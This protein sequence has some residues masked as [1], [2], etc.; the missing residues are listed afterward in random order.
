M[1]AVSVCKKIAADFLP[2]ISIITLCAALCLI[3][4]V[5][6]EAI[7]LDFGERVTVGLVTPVENNTGYR[8]WGSKYYPATYFHRRWRST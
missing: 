7:A 8:V 1:K 2:S 3:S 4:A 6:A 5:S